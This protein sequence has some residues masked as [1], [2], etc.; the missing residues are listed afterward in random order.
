MK[1]LLFSTLLALVLTGSSA[2]A[3]VVDLTTPNEPGMPTMTYATVTGFVDAGDNSVFHFEIN[4]ADGMGAFLNGGDNFG[5]DKFYF[6]TDLSLTEGMFLNLDPNTW[7]VN[8]INNNV[9]GFGLFDLELVDPGKRSLSLSF[10]IDYIAA[11]TEE[12]F[13][14]L[15]ADPAGNGNGHFAA[16]IGGFEYDDFGSIYV[17]DGDAP[18][19]VP[20]PGTLL[21]LGSGLLG[22]T[23]Y[24]RIRK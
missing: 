22:L 3:F 6:N 13:F 17:R 23:L 9:A 11:I 5:L 21:L 20:E 8:F 16:H 19:P 2:L 7:N 18:P 4:L 14:L 15:S 12:N 10:D 1:K 24:R